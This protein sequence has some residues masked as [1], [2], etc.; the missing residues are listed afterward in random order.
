MFKLKIRAA[1]I[2]SISVY[3][4]GE[5]EHLVE[6]FGP[7]STYTYP[8]YSQ[9]GP[10]LPDIPMARLRTELAANLFGS[11]TQIEFYY[12]GGSYLTAA[13]GRPGTSSSPSSHLPASDGYSG[14]DLPGRLYLAGRAP[15][16][17]QTE[18]DDRTSVR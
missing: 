1:L 9:M 3:G 12:C 4:T 13:Y 10:R 17:L 14:E 2:P 5:T 11:R 15:C 18:K 16:M 7:Q 8:L 6:L